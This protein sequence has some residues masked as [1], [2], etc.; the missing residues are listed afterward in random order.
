RLNGLCV[1]LFATTHRDQT[2]HP[3]RQTY[4]THGRPP[5]QGSCP[6]LSGRNPVPTARS[7]LTRA[8][9]PCR[10]CSRSLVNRRCER[11][12]VNAGEREFAT[13]LVRQ[14]ARPRMFYPSSAH[15]TVSMA[16]NI[17][18]GSPWVLEEPVELGLTAP[19]VT[20]VVFAS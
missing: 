19:E 13:G 20:A 1:R 2:R 6:R 16:R 7:C 18:S 12:R 15:E 17:G 14:R 3:Q 9:C 4:S 10:L 5:L 11:R 8:N